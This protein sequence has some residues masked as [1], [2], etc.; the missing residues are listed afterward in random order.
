MNA[1]LTGS[2][3]YGIVTPESDCDFVVLVD[4]A[5]LK[6]MQRWADKVTVW[7]NGVSLHYGRLNIIACIDEC[8]YAAWRLGTFR[9]EKQ[10]PVTKDIADKVLHELLPNPKRKAVPDGIQS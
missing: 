10:K 5:T 9:L 1:F 7:D 4:E 3:K 8:V 2:C 6:S